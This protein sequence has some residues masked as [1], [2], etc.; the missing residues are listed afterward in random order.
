MATPNTTFT[1]ELIDQSHVIDFR[2]HKIY[3]QKVS[4]TSGLV[5]IDGTLQ[6]L[7]TTKLNKKINPNPNR[8]LDGTITGEVIKSK[9]DIPAGTEVED[10]ESTNT[11]KN[12]VNLSF[13]DDLSEPGERGTCKCPDGEIYTVGLSVTGGQP[14][15]TKGDSFVVPQVPKKINFVET[16]V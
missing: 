14:S 7:D 9:K 3:E 6:F 12:T 8:V 4:D 5:K 10:L 15:C 13:E 11:I 16:N 2:Y 1:T